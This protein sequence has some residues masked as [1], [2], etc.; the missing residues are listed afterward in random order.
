MLF[1]FTFFLNNFEMFFFHGCL[2]S[3]HGCLEGLH[4]SLEGLHGGLEGMHGC[5]VTMHG[6]LE[7]IHGCLEG[8][9]AVGDSISTELSTSFGAEN[10]AISRMF[11]P[12]SPSTLLQ[13]P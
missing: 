5:L 2:E 7:S 13:S 10:E 4:G 11:S 6:C 3:M 9:Y 1:F 8:M 12:L